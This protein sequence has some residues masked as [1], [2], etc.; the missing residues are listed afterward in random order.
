MID[1]D[2]AMLYLDFVA[3]RHRVWERRHAVQPAPWTDDPVLRTRK[4]TNMFRVLDPG[5]QF[6]LTDLLCD[7]PVDFIARCF[8]YRY[9]NLPAT[10]YAMRDA[11]GHYPT[12]EEMDIP[13]C[14]AII[15]YREMGHK[16]FSGAYVILPQP[17]RPGDKVVQAVRLARQFVDEKAVDFLNAETQAER[18]TVLRSLYGCGDFMAMQILTDWGYGQQ[19][20]RE[21]EFVMPGPGCAKGARYLDPQAAPEETLMWAVQ[22]VTTD[23]R[24]P[25]VEGRVPS[26]MDVQNTLCEFSKYVRYEAKPAPAKD[27]NPVHP[28]VQPKPTLP[29]WW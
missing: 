22:A 23:P 19:E 13:L 1:P 6:V 18:F 28:G 29:T 14:D 5:S 2:M 4:F 11:F 21:N 17:N 20:D 3:E 26:W 27:Y 16:V 25:V 10:W 12:A 15:Q 7:D 8:L 9:T 24:C